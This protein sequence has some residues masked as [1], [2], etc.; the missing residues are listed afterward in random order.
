MR[1]K[2][3]PAMLL[4]ISWETPLMCMFGLFVRIIQMYVEVM[5]KPATV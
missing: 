2:K 5:Q 3:E 4:Y 1:E